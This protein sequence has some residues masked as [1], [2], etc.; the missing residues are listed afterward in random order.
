MSPAQRYEARVFR[1]PGR[2]RVL[3]REVNT[4]VKDDKTLRDLLEQLVKEI[5]KTLRVDLDKYHMEIYNPGGR[6]RAVVK[7]VNG[8]TEVTRP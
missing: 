6:R 7:I 3:T 4:N 5:E 1:S 2:Y 8:Q